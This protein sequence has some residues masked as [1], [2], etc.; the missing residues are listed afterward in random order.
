MFDKLKKCNSFHKNTF[1][2]WRVENLKYFFF[3]NSFDCGSVLGMNLASVEQNRR[4]LLSS[5]EVTCIPRI[6]L[7]QRLHFIGFNF[8]F[9]K[10]WGDISENL[11]HFHF[12]VFLIFVAMG[13]DNISPKWTNSTKM[14]TLLKKV[15]QI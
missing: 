3:L 11:T 1:N 15:I 13:Y 7:Q 4:S 5:T 14:H 10:N 6:D 8:Q 9:R 12:P 2:R